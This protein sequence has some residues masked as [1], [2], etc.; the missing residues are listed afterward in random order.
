MTRKIKTGN[1]VTSSDSSLVGSIK[2]DRRGFLIGSTVVSGAA[3]A[4]SVVSGASAASAKTTLNITTWMGFEPGRKEAWESIIGKYN[5]QSTTA[6]VKLTGWP[7]AQYVNQVLTGLEAGT[8]TDDLIMSTPDLAV[9]LFKGGRFLPLTRPIKN[10]GVTPNP[11]IHAYI[12]DSAGIHYGVSVVTVN[13]GLLYNSDLYKKAGLKPP[14]TPEELLA[15]SKKLTK[16]PNQYGFWHPNNMAEQGDFWFNLQNWVNMYDGVW[17]VGKTPKANSPA[18][19]K[20]L[21]LW[22]KLYNSS[23]P[24]GINNAASLQ[25]VSA[26]RL[27]QGFWVSAAVNSIKST[28]AKTYAKLRSVALPHA[29]H[30]AASRVHP[31]SIN[32]LGQNQAEAE[33]FLSWLFKPENMADLTMQCLDFIP[34]FP[35]MTK[36]PAFNKYL[37]SLPWIDGFLTPPSVPITPMD[38]MGDFITKSDEVGTI[39][40]TNLQGAMTGKTTVK[41]AMDKAQTQM[42]A[43]A[44]KGL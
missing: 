3:V 30:K 31:I 42:V 33:A 2:T 1:S 17:A 34:P 19:V 29:S 7:F 36:V 20:A 18:V 21:D 37:K 27:A 8:L 40:L 24:K 6:E 11:K 16:K 12:T 28:N 38:M 13:F 25:L 4:S 35:E 9:R 10:A 15:T 22:L 14:R 43:L 44:A 39:I 23:I 32:K 26:G 41:K 5:A